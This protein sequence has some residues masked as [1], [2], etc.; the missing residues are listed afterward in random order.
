VKGIGRR[1]EAHARL[2]RS[3]GVRFARRKTAKAQV[4]GS[5]DLPRRAGRAPG[6]CRAGGGLA[7]R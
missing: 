4:R 2:R 3:T 1:R 5:G 6:R 7:W